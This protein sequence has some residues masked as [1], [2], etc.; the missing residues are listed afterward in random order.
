MSKPGK[1]YQTA[2]LDQLRS[3]ALKLTMEAPGLVGDDPYLALGAL[4][5]ASAYVAAIVKMPYKDLIKMISDHYENA[6]LQ[7]VERD[8]EKAREGVMVRKPAGSV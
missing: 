1:P 3:A 5:L 2:E 4:S 6:L 7:E 8:L